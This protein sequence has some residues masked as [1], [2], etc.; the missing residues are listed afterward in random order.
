MKK[1]VT[2]AMQAALERCGHLDV[3]VAAEAQ[4][5]WASA[6]TLPLQEGV[7]YGDVIGGIFDVEELKPGVAPE[8]P[9]S[10][11]TP[12]NV[13]EFVAW[14]VPGNGLIPYKSFE[15][16]YV[17]VPTYDVGAA[18]D[19]NSKYARDARFPVIE[20]LFK[21]VRAMFTRKLNNDGFHTILAAGK[22][23]NLVAYDS[24]AV[25]GLFTKRL[26]NALQVTMERNAGG[27]S[28]SEDKGVLSD[29]YLSPESMGD[30]RSWDL[31]QID[32]FTRRDIFIGEGY[33]GLTKIFGV[34]LHSLTEL[35]VSQEWQ[36]YYANT[37]G[38]TMPT[39]KAEIV[40]GLDLVNRDSFV[41]PVREMPMVQ[42]DPYLARHRRLGI[43]GTCEI[44]FGALD[45][46]RVL[47][48]AV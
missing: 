18:A 45:T 13:K 16:D 5:E 23:R 44:G 22:G 4:R 31:T 37:L 36:N 30:I 28:T 10:P 38:G 24:A 48:G 11:I 41:M 12:S 47:L 1:K 25:S 39:D 26:V 9:L 20:R 6:L 35:G 14:T 29:L 19:V 43:W 7:L 21:M 42:S 2:A 46:R 40:V 27:N 33:G 8:Y 3:A 34:L 32:E 15:S 17:M